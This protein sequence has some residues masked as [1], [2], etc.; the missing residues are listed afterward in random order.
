M[1][2][3]LPRGEITASR[4][5]RYLLQQAISRVEK[6]QGPVDDTQYHLFLLLS[7]DAAC[8]DRATS[9]RLLANAF[10]IAV[11]T[12]EQTKRLHRLESLAIHASVI[13]RDLS[14]EALL[15]IRNAQNRKNLSCTE[16]KSLAIDLVLAHSR[17]PSEEPDITSRAEKFC[18]EH[19]RIY[20]SDIV[21]DSA[22]AFAEYVSL[23]D[24]NLGAGIWTRFRPDQAWDQRFW[25]AEDLVHYGSRLA[26]AELQNLLKRAPNK[27]SRSKTVVA[28]YCAGDKRLALAALVDLN[29][30]VGRG[31]PAGDMLYRIACT[32]PNSAVEIAKSFGTEMGV[33]DAMSIVLEAIAAT[34]PSQIRRFLPYQDNEHRRAYSLVSA[35][36]S[37]T[38]GGDIKSATRLAREITVAEQ[39]CVALAIVAECARDRELMDEALKLAWK[40]DLYGRSLRS[41]TACAI[42]AFGVGDFEQMLP[43]LIPEVQNS[44]K[45]MRVFAIADVVAERDPAWTL[46][47]FKGYSN[48]TP[49]PEPTTVVMSYLELLPKLAPVDSEFMLNYLQEHAKKSAS[50]RDKSLRKK[51]MESL[52]RESV[53][54]AKQFA[55]S[56]G[57]SKSDID[58]RQLEV[59]YRSWQIVKDP[60]RV[61]QT[62]EQLRLQFP[63]DRRYLPMRSVEIMI[64]WQEDYFRDVEGVIQLAGA[65]ADRSLADE[66]L[67]Q[68]ASL[69][70]QL[71]VDRDAFRLLNRVQS[72]WWQAKVLE[73]MAYH[74][75]FPRPRERISFLQGCWADEGN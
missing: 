58:D 52:A 4:D 68:G 37:L 53:A 38:A 59:I 29:P 21:S 69:L 72:P 39:K 45:D 75:L 46:D 35:V 41:I 56:L 61:E 66:A 43:R 18:K 25:I 63:P 55:E 24:P 8:F 9:A 62:L 3:A 1:P 22:H 50:L 48:T 74:E 14:I 64:G 33:R 6:V 65:L 32:D 67:S 11:S 7:R 20:K 42:R 57:L 73:S 15:I 44:W 49:I 51:C 5:C 34:W 31:Q 54:K 27:E 28:L 2:G 60:T 40:E 17:N 71:G 70:Y 10:K 12:Q 36:Q 30:V 19:E 23:L 47:I 16:L 26:S 13:D